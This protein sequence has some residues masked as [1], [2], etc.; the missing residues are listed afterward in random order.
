MLIKFLQENKIK[1]ETDKSLS[2]MTSFKIGGTAKLV[3]YPDNTE[4]CCRL[5]SFLSQNKMSYFTMGNGSNLLFDDGVFE[6]PIIR[7]DLLNSMSCDGNIFTFGAG[8]KMATAA[9]FAA[10]NGYSGMEFAH[11]IPG[12]IG[13]A[14]YMN[15]GAYDG[16]MNQIVVSTRYVDESGRLLSIEGGAHDFS[17]RHSFFSHKKM[18]IVETS[19]KLISADKQAIRDKMADLMQRRKD[20]QPLNLPSAGSTFKRPKGAFAG[21]LIEQCGLRGYQIGGARVSDKHCGFVVNQDNASFQDV[22]DL[23]VFVQ[24]TVKEKT[25][26][27]LECEVE[28][29]RSK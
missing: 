3:I 8:V 26:Y 4:K 10:R 15:A 27:I 28:I 18:L 6:E 12:S 29:V 23:I 24:K 9:N 2:E 17:Y 16:A 11:G 7:T 1:Y 14:V 13:G 19:V 21:Q 22:M 5:I 25:G 20:K